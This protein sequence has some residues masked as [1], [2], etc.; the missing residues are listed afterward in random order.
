MGATEVAA[1]GNWIVTAKFITLFFPRSLVCLF[2]ETHSSHS[3]LFCKY[4]VSFCL[5]SETVAK[6]IHTMTSSHRM[7]TNNR[8]TQVFTFCVFLK[9]I[10]KENHKKL[11]VPCV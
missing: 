2:F 11:C 8:P 1:E 4:L 7:N 9:D 10:A 3:F 6:R 5:E